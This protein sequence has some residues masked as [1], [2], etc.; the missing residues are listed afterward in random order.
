MDKQFA[1]C[2]SISTRA[3]TLQPRL[4]ILRPQLWPTPAPPIRYEAAGTPTLPCRVLAT[5]PALGG[6]GQVP[7]LSHAMGI[8]TESAI[9][10]QSKKAQGETNERLDRLIGAVEHNSELLEELVKYLSAGRGG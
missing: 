8:G 1:A 2:P 3:S 5:R 6:G 7:V 10:T 9:L 4:A